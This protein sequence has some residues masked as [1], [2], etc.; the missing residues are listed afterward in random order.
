MRAEFQA[1]VSGWTLTSDVEDL[2]EYLEATAR[3]IATADGPLEA[4]E[5]RTIAMM[6]ECQIARGIR[7]G[8]FE[9]FLISDDDD[10][11]VPGD[12]E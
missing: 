5:E 6:V 1:I 7:R 3:F 12:C 9:P 10:E 2:G 4:D 8:D 11:E